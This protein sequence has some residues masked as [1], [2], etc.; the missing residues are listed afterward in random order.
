MRTNPFYDGWL[1]LIGQTEDHQKS[2]AGYP[3]AALFLLITSV[4]HD[5]SPL[6]CQTFRLVGLSYRQMTS[7]H[8]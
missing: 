1:F 6:S 2:G 8:L 5:R 4:L 3:L 7:E